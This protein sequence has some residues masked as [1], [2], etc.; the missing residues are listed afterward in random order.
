MNIGLIGC[1]NMGEALLGGF[2]HAGL[3]E[4]DHIYVTTL[5]EASRK[6]IRHDY[7]VQVVSDAIKLVTCADA[8]IL[9]TKP[10]VYE[11]IIEEIK[12]YLT[13][14]HLIISITPAFTLKQLRRLC[15]K[16]PQIVRTMP[17][18]PAK[19]NQGVT[20]ISFESNTSETTKALVNQI[21]RTVGTIAE[22]NEDDLSLVG[23]LSGSMPAFF[24]YFLKSVLEYG[25]EKG[26]DRE[27]TQLLVTQT[28]QG[29]LQ[30]VEKSNLEPKTLIEQVCSKGGSTIEAIRYFDEHQLETT[31]KQGLDQT[32]KRFLAME[33]EH[34]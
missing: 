11:S 20:G 2:L 9:A 24:L 27:T 6:R 13:A 15:G 21:F 32:T 22:V 17:N 1:G 19:I 14:H 26:L 18:T 10:N 16:N 33:C 34:E 7:G 25:Q 23:T 8:I 29:T 31:I 5:T 30:L 12:P 4:R 28:I 3:F